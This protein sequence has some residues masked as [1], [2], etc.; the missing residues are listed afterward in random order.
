MPKTPQELLRQRARKKFWRR[1]KGPLRCYYCYVIVSRELPETNPTKA[2]IDH[3]IP[4]CEG[5]NSDYENLVLSCYKCN[6]RR[7]NKKG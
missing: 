7:A 2:T 1:Y 6:Q 5:G 4:I 3:I